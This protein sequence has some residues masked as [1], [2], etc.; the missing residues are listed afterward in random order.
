MERTVILYVDDEHINLKLFSLAFEKKFRVEIADSGVEGLRKLN[1]LPEIEVVISD[2][3]MPGMNGIDF[4]KT[5]KSNYPD[6]SYY[7][8]T[9]FDISTEISNALNQGL[10]SSYFRKPF[11]LREIEAAIHDAMK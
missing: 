7:I 10:I 6:V 11:N 8:L 3:K 2:M 4:I 5:A 1:S 9:G